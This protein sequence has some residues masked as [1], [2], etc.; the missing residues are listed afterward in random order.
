MIRF[1]SDYQEGAHPRILQRLAEINLVQSPGY[2]EDAFCEEA[3]RI[4]REKCAAPKA[5]VQFLVGGTQTNFTLLA[6]ALR[7]HQG[8]IAADSGHIAVH[9][10]GAVE[11]CGHKVIEL[12]A[13][14]ANSRPVRF[15]NTAGS[16]SPTARASTW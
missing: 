8:V 7:P 4:I 12:P 14:T 10:T 9:E 16:T 15:R 13:R 5:D 3:R 11:A 6:A 1:G 2:G